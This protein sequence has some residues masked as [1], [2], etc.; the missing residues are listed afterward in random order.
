MVKEQKNENWEKG[1][2]RLNNNNNA[3][4][5]IKELQKQRG[6]M[7]ERRGVNEEFGINI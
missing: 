5:K 4:N 1:R 3:N 2:E 7:E 6:N